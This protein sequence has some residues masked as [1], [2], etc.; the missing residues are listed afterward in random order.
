GELLG[1]LES[2]RSA[3]TED[4]GV[5]VRE[6]RG[7]HDGQARVPAEVVAENARVGGEAY[8]AGAEAGTANDVVG[9]AP[10]LEKHL[11]LAR[12]EAELQ[13]WG[14]RPYDDAID[15]HDPGFTTARIEGLFDELKAAL[16]PFVREIAAS[17]VQADRARLQ[18]FPVEH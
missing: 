16:V 12:E 9:Y 13:G 1:E 7:N 10:Y 6:A 5:V 15:Q 17:P 4:Q 14:N 3:L 11:E 8:D 2:V 18:G